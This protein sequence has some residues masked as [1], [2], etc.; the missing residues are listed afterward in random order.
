M[1]AMRAE[2]NPFPGYLEAP[3]SIT[4]LH[5]RHGEPLQDLVGERDQT[6]SALLTD[7]ATN[8]YRMLPAAPM[9]SSLVEEGAPPIRPDAPGEDW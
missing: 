7:A 3:P 6:L 8:Y 9:W 1:G 5:K 4:Q 2:I